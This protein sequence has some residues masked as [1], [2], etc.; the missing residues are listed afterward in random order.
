MSDFEWLTTLV[1]L[2][3]LEHEKLSIGYTWEIDSLNYQI[4]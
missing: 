4:H 3:T 2:L 1:Q